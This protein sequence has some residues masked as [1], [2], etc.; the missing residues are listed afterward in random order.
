MNNCLEHVLHAGILGFVLYFI[1][2]QMGQSED[3]ACN[4]SG[5]IAGVAFV[6]MILFG[7]SFPPNNLNSALGF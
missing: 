4:R 7:H 2:K 1:M 5:L 6:Y 3:K